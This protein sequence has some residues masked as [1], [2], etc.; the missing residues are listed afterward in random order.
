M[1]KIIL[2]FIAIS[3]FTL[4]AKAKSSF[5]KGKVDVITSLNLGKYK[6]CI[7]ACNA[8]I[9]TCKT[10]ETECI[11]EKNAKMD[12][13]I[14]LCKECISACTAASQ[15]MTL[16]SEHSKEMCLVC[17][18]ICENCALECEKHNMDHC[19]KCATNCRKAA[20]LCKEM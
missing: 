1:K 12:K 7:E 13:C 18:K 16:N 5:S 20:K 2:T 9:I 19:K 3:I 4:T 6:A 17:A 15:L 8:C 11:K 14:Q 10:C